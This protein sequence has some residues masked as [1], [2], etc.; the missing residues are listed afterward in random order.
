MTTTPPAPLLDLQVIQE[1]VGV[2]A[3]SEGTFMVQLLQTFVSDAH[4]ALARMQHHAHAGDSAALAR[5]AHRLKGSS[6]TVGATQLA[7]ECRAIE[8][9]A[10]AGSCA[11]LDSSIE[12]A[13][14]VL[15]ATRVRIAEFFRGT[16]A[17]AT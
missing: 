15:D 3:D 17:T 13:R 11:G 7:G 8:H 16:I 6:G 14:Q 1:I 10:R 12:Q 5:E 2:T 9:T 4:D